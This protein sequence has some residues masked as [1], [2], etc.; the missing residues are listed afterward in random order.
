M[1]LIFL[2]LAAKKLNDVP[3]LDP[4]FPI[5]LGFVFRAVPC[6]SGSGSLRIVPILP[7]GR[8]GNAVCRN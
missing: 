3:F 5:L 8:R 4:L 7:G 1:H 6:G 2:P